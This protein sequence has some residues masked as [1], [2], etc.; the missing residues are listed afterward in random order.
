MQYYNVDEVDEH[1]TALEAERD[2]LKTDIE[3]RRK[4]YDLVIEVNNQLATKGARLAPRSLNLPTCFY[5]LIFAASI[6][7]A[8]SRVIPRASASAS[9]AASFT[10]A[11]FCAAL[12]LAPSGFHSLAQ[13]RNS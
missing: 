9:A 13:A 5:L 8:C 3:V 7:C 2:E 11:T 6:A 10:A 12:T 1:I 4:S